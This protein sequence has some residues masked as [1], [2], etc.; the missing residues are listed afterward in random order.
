MT[1]PNHPPLP[2]PSFRDACEALTN[3]GI[4]QAVARRIL[5]SGYIVGVTN[6]KTPLAKRLPAIQQ[7]LMNI[8][9]S[10]PD[11]LAREVLRETADLLAARRRAQ[12]GERPATE[13][14][15]PSQQ[16]EWTDG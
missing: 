7:T 6:G 9:H 13:P 10:L 14:P 5:G 15:S 8:V 16:E 4:S 2:L 11:A 3:A 12:R 1:D